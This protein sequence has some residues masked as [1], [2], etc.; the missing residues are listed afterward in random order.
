[1]AKEKEEKCCDS[2]EKD[3]CCCS[4]TA[5][6]SVDEKGQLVL[7]KDIRNWIGLKAGDKLAVVSMGGK[8]DPCCLMLMRADSLNEAVRVK[9]DMVMGKKEKKSEE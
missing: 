4:V 5:I 1:M 6:V 9:I 7:P 2:K 8:A 3:T